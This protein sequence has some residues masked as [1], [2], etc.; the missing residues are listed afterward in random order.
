MSQTVLLV[1]IGPRRPGRI[2]EPRIVGVLRVAVV[3]GHQA[4]ALRPLNLAAHRPV[5]RLAEAGDVLVVHSPG[6]RRDELRQQADV[7][8]SDKKGV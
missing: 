5:L 1:G 2:E 7:L 3:A 6:V 8:C 4:E